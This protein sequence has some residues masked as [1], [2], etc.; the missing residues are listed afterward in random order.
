VFKDRKNGGSRSGER[1]KDKYRVLVLQD[2][3]F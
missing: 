3:E 2:E 1:G